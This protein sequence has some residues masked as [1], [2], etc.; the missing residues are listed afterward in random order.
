MP[1]LNGHSAQ[2]KQAA[3]TANLRVRLLSDSPGVTEYPAVART[4]V[5]IHVGPPSFVACLRGGE[6]HRGTAVHGDIDI[7]PEGT[8]SRW[9]LKQ[10]D[11]ALV[12][13]LA[14]EFLR[15]VAEESDLDAG[16]L[17]FR[18]RFQIRDAQIEHIGWA[19]Q[20]EMERNYA[21]GRLFWDG[22]AAA[23]AAR[24]VHSHSSLARKT[25]TANGGFSGRKLKQVLEYIEEN[26]ATNLS[27]SD[28]AAAAGLSISHCKV[29]FR[30]SLGLPVHQYLIRRRVERAVALLRQDKLSISQVA[31]ESG[32]SHQSHLA[33]HMRRLLGVSPRELRNALQ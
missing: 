30:Q 6:S 23:L 11:R 18:N 21:G 12:L 13:S 8:P 9:E 10:C 4:A 3:Q 25:V 19:L 2:A 14:P 22:M 32:F 17:E 1:S 27:L 15:R 20:E 7:V 26:L 28:I 29:L 33:M 24:L 31:L 5:S 16:R